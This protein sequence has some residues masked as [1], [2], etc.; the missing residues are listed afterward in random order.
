MTDPT[1]KPRWFHPTPGWLIVALL[2]VEGLLW[3]SER[4][5]WP[6]WHKGYAVLIAVA[7]V[8]LVFVVMLLWLGVALVAHLRF[9][10]S[11]GSLL[12]LTV[13]VAIPSSWLAVEMKA[14]KEQQEAVKEITK[15][16]GHFLYDCNLDDTDQY[17]PTAQPPGPPWL[18]KV[19]TDDFFQAVVRVDIDSYEIT[20]AGL[21]R[22][23]GLTQLR[24]LLLDNAQ[25]TDAGLAHLAGL[26]RLELLWLDTPETTDAGLAHLAG[27]TRLKF[28]TLWHT[29]I[30][31]SGLAHL[32]RL[33]QLQW[34]DLGSTHNITDAGLAHLAGLT[35]L[36]QLDLSDTPITDAGLAHLAR[37]TQLQHLGL[38]GTRI[39]DAGVAKLQDALPNCQ[40]VH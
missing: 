24:E 17:I 1:P 3:L 8:G 16:G 18:R 13:A 19:L 37:L 25:I 29:Q 35:Q 14:A 5:Q 4:F 28:L 6:T 15:C 11:I 38:I 20:D 36:Q 40:I 39:T 30:T 31:D 23:A 2:V 10:F 9:Q 12:I 27:L 33:T 7:V 26:T 32:A 34:L 22:L 21:A